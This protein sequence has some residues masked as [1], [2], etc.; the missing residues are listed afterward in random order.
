MFRPP[1]ARY[2]FGL[3]YCFGDFSDVLLKAM[4]IVARG[5]RERIQPPQYVAQIVGTPKMVLF[6]NGSSVDK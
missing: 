4:R 1:T 6:R 5:L 3:S 2:C